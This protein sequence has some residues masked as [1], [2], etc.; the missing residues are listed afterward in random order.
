MKQD[1]ASQT[2]YRVAI[3]R[4]AHQLLDAPKVLDDPIAL[5]IVGTEGVAII[6]AGGRQFS[7]RFARRLRAF[8]VGR[9]RFAEDE[10][11]QAV[12]RGV[13]QYV[14]L[15]AGLDTFAYRNPYPASRL[16]VFE[17]DHP[18]TQAWKR[19]QLDAAEIAIPF[20]LTFVPVNFETQTLAAQ[21]RLAGFRTDEPTFFSWLGVTMYLTPEVVMATMTFIASAT[22]GGGGIVFDYMTPMSREGIFRRLRLRLLTCWLAAVGEPW[23]SFFDADVLTRELKEIGFANIADMGSEDINIRY[24]PNRADKLKVSGPGHWMCAQGAPAV[25][26]RDHANIDSAKT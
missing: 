6:R 9:S 10:L 5:R 17:V 24:F 23:R 1:R 15:G 19:K 26:S 7:S 4:A 22:R 14:I 20:A 18:S 16:R 13:R 3:S 8:F 12:R 11:A 25:R 21:L 2:A